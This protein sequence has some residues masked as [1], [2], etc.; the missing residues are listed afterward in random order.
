MKVNQF[1]APANVMNKKDKLDEMGS[2]NKPDHAQDKQN[3]VLSMS[4]NHK[5]LIGAKSLM[6]ALN[7]Q[8]SVNSS[9]SFSSS[10]QQSISV[11]VE[12]GS[13]LDKIDVEPISFDFEAVA[14]N[15]MDF[16]SGAIYGAKSGG[17]DDAKLNLM[18]QQAREGIDKGFDMAREELGSMDMLTSDVEQ[19]IDKSYDLIQQGMNDLDKSLFGKESATTP[20]VSSRA[21][22]LSEVETGSIDIQTRDGDKISI[23][24]GQ[25]AQLSQSQSVSNDSKHTE[26]STSHGQSFN[27]TVEGDLN[28][29]EL[30][31][32]SS[33]VGDM[34]QLADD[35]FSGNVE[36]AWQQANE[37]GFDS[38]QIVSFAYDFKEVKQLAI[39]EHY[40]T[41]KENGDQSSNN[42]IAT[43]SPYVKGLDD[44]M[45]A[46]ES[47]FAGDNVKQLINDVANK[48]LDLMDQMVSKT[49]DSF[50]DFNQKILNSL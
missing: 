6:A 1:T 29:D 45:K 37:L 44:V 12:T 19:G 33:L 27:L 15:V 36:Q 16:V 49:L 10:K 40:A 34:A 4:S 9:F 3:D 28:D 21:I 5:L 7:Q 41:V 30:E 14:K 24:F 23:S 50:N 39:T 22:E 20:Q 35:F 13:I 48:Q 26:I 8:L 18:M 31:A 46:G 25:S 32:I 11:D 43:L 2:N 17:A 42:P 47:L 38:Q